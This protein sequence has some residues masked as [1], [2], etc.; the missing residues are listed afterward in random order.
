VDTAVVGTSVTVLFAGDSEPQTYRLVAEHDKHVEDAVSVSSPLGQAV[1][2][3]SA[4]EVVR[5]VAPAGDLKVTI[6]EIA[7]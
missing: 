5:V 4:G 1:H 2:G 6:V 3:A 7:P